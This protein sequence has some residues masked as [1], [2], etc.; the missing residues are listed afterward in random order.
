LIKCFKVS[1]P[2]KF[3][4]SRRTETNIKEDKGKGITPFTSKEFPKK[5]KGK[6]CFKF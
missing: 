5:L 6:K 2:S 1:T 3:F 4:L